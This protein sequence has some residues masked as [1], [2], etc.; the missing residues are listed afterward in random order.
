[1]S[2]PSTAKELAIVNSMEAKLSKL[3]TV[4]QTEEEAFLVTDALLSIRR[5]FNDVEEK[6]KSYTAPF[7]EG[8]KN[9]NNDFKPITG[10][11][12]DWETKLGIALDVYADSRVEEDT[13]K[14]EKMREQTGDPAL[15]IPVG[16]K[17][18]PSPS[19]EI[20]FRK[21]FDVVV[22]DVSAV[23]SKYLIV[24]VKAVEKDIKELDGNIS[25]PGI[26]FRPTHTHAIYLK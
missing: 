5:V 11:L 25:I 19:G 23:P 24:D 16:L 17:A 8:V 21:G 14:L 12:Q 22:T 9:I 1:M 15:M 7:N 3:P 13:N 20:R 2:K 4:I 10:P 6:R 18:L 26:S